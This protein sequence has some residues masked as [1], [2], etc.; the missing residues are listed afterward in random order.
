MTFY[1]FIIFIKEKKG[2]ERPKGD[3]YPPLASGII[4]F[5]LDY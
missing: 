3:G 1:D 5:R 4:V 2:E